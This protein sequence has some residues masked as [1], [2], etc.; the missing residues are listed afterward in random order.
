M[1]LI[2][3]ITRDKH[4]E[5]IINSLIQED[6]RVTKI[7]STGGFLR[8]GMTT[9]MIGVED[10]QV[11]NVFDNLRNIC[12]SLSEDNERCITIFV[13]NVSQFMQV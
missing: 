6:Y 7:A 3:A 8:R 11:E 9:L 12:G 4:S 5:E 10:E 13:L 2:I 1:K